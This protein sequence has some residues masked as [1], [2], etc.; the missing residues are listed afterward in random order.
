MTLA[1]VTPDERRRVAAEGLRKYG[2]GGDYMQL[3]D[4]VEV[5]TG[6][7]RTGANDFALAL[8]DLIDPTCEM[9]RFESDSDFT[10][11]SHYKC[12]RC[13]CDLVIDEWDA[14]DDYRVI[15]HAPYCPR[16]GA[17]IVKEDA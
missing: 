16:C 7:W 10:D 8:A 14:A 4:V 3:A 9:V 13:G 5:V 6:N 2:S 15:S 17:R 11:E 12:S 1:S